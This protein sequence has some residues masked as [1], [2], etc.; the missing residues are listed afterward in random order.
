MVCL[1]MLYFVYP[2]IAHDIYRWFSNKGGQRHKVLPEATQKEFLSKDFVAYH[3]EELSQEQEE[4]LFARVQMG[5]QLSAAEKMRASSGPWQELAKLFVDDFPSVYALM[6]DRARAKDFQLTLSCFSQIVEVMDPTNGLPALR[7]NFAALPKFI[8]NKHL[9]DDGIK[10]HLAGIWNTLKELI[11]LDPDTFTNANKYLTG[12]QTFA[13]VEMVGVTV[14]LSMYSESRSS[15]LLLGDVQAL[16]TELRKQFIDLRLNVPTWK[17]MWEFCDGLRGAVNGSTIDRR[18]MSSATGPTPS[19]AS[20]VPSVEVLSSKKKVRTKKKSRDESGQIQQP[21]PV[22]TIPGHSTRQESQ[23]A[24]LPTPSQ[25]RR[26]RSSELHGNYTNH[27]KLAVQP[28]FFATSVPADL[29]VETSR[30]SASTLQPLEINHP[31]SRIGIGAFTPATIEQQWAGIVSSISPQI[32]PQ[33]AP[34]TSSW[35]H[36][37][38]R[39]RKSTTHLPPAHYRDMVDLTGEDGDGGECVEQKR[40]KSER[41]ERERIE[42]ERRDLL[43]SFKDKSVAGKRSP[44][45]STHTPS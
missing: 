19:L 7:T 38:Q 11:E 39:K 29:A 25:G 21:H 15:T 27:A 17:F 40:V 45:V 9:I 28:P 37:G 3:F 35:P 16:R 31:Q 41:H 13:P 6:K 12:V 33:T 42:M 24:P 23:E 4:D 32:S 34:S 5:M 36:S 43:L 26:K 14:L 20:A 1:L 22:P 30:A 18:P 8:S 10:A 44:A 2:K